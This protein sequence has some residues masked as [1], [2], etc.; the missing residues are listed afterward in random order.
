M[1]SS[2]PLI[3]PPRFVQSEVD[4]D[5]SAVHTFA[6]AM[7][8]VAACDG[9]HPRELELIDA[10]EAQVPG[11]SG[12]VDLATLTTAAHKAAFLKSLVLVAFADGQ[13]TDAE[14]AI[15][16]RYADALG[17]DADTRTKAWTEVASALLS[18]FS[19]VRTYRSQVVALGESMGLDKST[20]DSILG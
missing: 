13:V 16:T 3:Q 19:G 2:S 9:D 5:A 11:P 20:I 17:I 8:E 18:V 14:R 12:Q 15:I 4:L 10:F 1:S 7:R 6:A